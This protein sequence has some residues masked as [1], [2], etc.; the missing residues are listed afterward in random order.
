MD[1]FHIYLPKT[2]SG[3]VNGT[4][5]H[6]LRARPRGGGEGPRDPSPPPGPGSRLHPK[7]EGNP[8]RAGCSPQ[9]AADG[10][11]A[12]LEGGHEALLSTLQG[13]LVAHP[14]LEAVEDPSYTGA[15]RLDSSDGLREGDRKSVV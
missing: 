2:F 3:T 14:I 6:F 15:Q 13:L 9:V 12:L 8:L 11:Q 10:V 4:T 7:A 5:G 1:R